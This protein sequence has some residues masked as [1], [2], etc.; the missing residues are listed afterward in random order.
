[1]KQAREDGV[2]DWDI[3]FELAQFGATYALMPRTAND[4]LAV[5]KKIEDRVMSEPDEDDD[6][7]DQ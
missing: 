2:T 6:G 5:A 7:D 1:M 4:P 3:L